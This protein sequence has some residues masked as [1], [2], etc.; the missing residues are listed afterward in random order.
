MHPLLFEIDLGELGAFPLRT[1]GALLALG[2][3][4]ALIFARFESKRIGVNPVVIADLLIWVLGG[5]IIGARLLYVIIHPEE[6]PDLVAVITLWKGGLVYYGGFIGGTLGGI[7][8]ARKNKINILDL[9]DLSMPAAM[10]GQAIGRWGCFMAGCCYGKE[11]GP[12]FPLGVPFPEVDGSLIPLHLQN[13]DPAHPEHFLH[14]TQIYMSVNALMLWL[15]LWFVLRHRK[16]RGLVT[17]LFLVL[18]AV[19]RSSLEVLRGDYA[20]RVFYGPLSTSQWTSVP[21]LLF[22]LYLLFTCKKRPVPTR[23]EKGGPHED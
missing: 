6:F 15:I 13:T 2:F 19:S 11:A 8:F 22:G 14:P 4:A 17:G 10:L 3:L 5:G 21:I 16:H 1:Y 9:A 7:L 12:E 18:Y 23:L 20:E